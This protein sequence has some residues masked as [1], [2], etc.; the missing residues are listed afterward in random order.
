MRFFQPARWQHLAWVL[1]AAAALF[2]I[3]LL[4]YSAA[5]GQ[6][7]RSLD[8]MRSALSAT[9]DLLHGRTLYRREC[10]A[11]HGRKA[12]GNEAALVPAL[13]GQVPA[14]TVKLLYDMGEGDRVNPRMDHTLA[15]A[16]LLDAT[17]IASVAAYVATLPINRRPKTGDGSQLEAGQR[18]YDKTCAHCHGVDGGGNAGWFVPSLRGQHYSYLLVQMRQLGTSQRYAVPPLVGHL[19][20]SMSLEQLSAVA[21]ATSRLSTPPQR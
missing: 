16:G 5:A 12:H 1:G 17:A 9:P 20:E 2:L 11:C 21:D 4:W 8:A 14:Y 6:T 19:L 13:A 7:Q 15:S 3:L 10:A 18:L